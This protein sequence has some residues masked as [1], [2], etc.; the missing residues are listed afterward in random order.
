M[1]II[2]VNIKM[3]ILKRRIRCVICAMRWNNWFLQQ[4]TRVQRRMKGLGTMNTQN[5]NTKLIHSFK[6]GTAAWDPFTLNS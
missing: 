5:K 4:K 6:A 3:E 1:L 2:D